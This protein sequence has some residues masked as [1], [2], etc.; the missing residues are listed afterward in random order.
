MNGNKKT[1]QQCQWQ[2]PVRSAHLKTLFLHPY[3]HQCQEH[4][5]TRTWT[6]LFQPSTS[7][8][9]WVSTVHMASSISACTLPSVPISKLSMYCLDA[10][11][12]ILVLILLSACNFTDVVILPLMPSFLPEKWDHFYFPYLK[13]QLALF[14]G[15]SMVWSHSGEVRE[16]VNGN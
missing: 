10:S 1:H 2:G 5:S 3:I 4:K 15:D 13:V 12:W 7:W 14:L 9:L 6:P 16:E 8:R 11:F